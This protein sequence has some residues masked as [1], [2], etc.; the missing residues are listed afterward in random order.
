MHV[1]LLLMV[2]LLFLFFLKLA[3]RRNSVLNCFMVFYTDLTRVGWRGTWTYVASSK[4]WRVITF[5]PLL[6]F[7]FQFANIA[8]M[9]T[10]VYGCSNDWENRFRTKKIK[11]KKPPE[12]GIKFYLKFISLFHL[13]TLFFF[14]E[15]KDFWFMVPAHSHH[16]SDT[17]YRSLS[18]LPLSLR[19]CM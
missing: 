17:I 19:T 4:T 2:T 16:R 3:T 5:P 11:N 6:I 1:E 9:H 18:L 13:M 14:L 7:V 12:Y 15:M 8:N 10:H